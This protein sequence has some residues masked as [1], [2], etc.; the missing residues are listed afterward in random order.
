ME[1]FVLGGLAARPELNGRRGVA[2][3]FEG[4]RYVVA[5]EGA[6]SQAVRVRPAHLSLGQASPAVRELEESLGTFSCRQKWIDWE[7]RITTQS[8]KNDF[9]SDHQHL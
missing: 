8:K 2:Q 4:D 6:G 1:E 9:S 3:S 7:S 5:L